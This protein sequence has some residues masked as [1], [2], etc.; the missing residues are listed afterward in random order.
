MKK[1]GIGLNS[2]SLEA[3]KIFK[4]PHA[5]Y[6]NALISWMQFRNFVIARKIGIVRGNETKINKLIDIKSNLL[7]Q[8]QKVQLRCDGD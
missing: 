3:F 7:I 1:E 6:A 2:V 5:F 4:A 8:T